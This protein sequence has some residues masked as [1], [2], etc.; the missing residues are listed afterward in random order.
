MNKEQFLPTPYC[1]SG[2]VTLCAVGARYG[3]ICEALER[4]GIEVLRIPEHGKLS[5]PVK[6]HADLQLAVLKG[7]QLLIAKGESD[8]RE[9]LEAYGFQ[10]KEAETEL[11]NSYPQEALLDFVST[12]SQ[13]IGNREI[14]GKIGLLNNS[15]IIHVKQGYTKCNLAL[16]NQ[17]AVITSDP[18]ITTACRKAGFDVLQI[19]PGFIELPGYSHGFIGGCC[20]LI[21]ADHLAVC[22]ELNTHPD[23][24][25]IH[26]FLT[27]HNVSVIE[28]CKGPLQDIGGIIPLKQ[29]V[30]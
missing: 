11:S 8:L 6:A 27:Q 1:P 26:R 29:K 30:K 21:S 7:E 5:Q 10:V 19:Q 4:Y 23:H 24:D 18:S 2:E 12:S 15:Q 28:L 13:I 3:K 9:L 25:R 20:G 14:I 16:I 17:N 22:G